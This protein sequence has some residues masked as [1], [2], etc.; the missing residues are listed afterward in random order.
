MGDINQ[1][2]YINFIP[3]SAEH[4]QFKNNLK[5]L[6]G[7]KLV[8]HMSEFEWMVKVIPDHISHDLQQEMSTASQIFMLPVLLKNEACYSDCLHILDSYVEDIN[9]IYTKACRGNF[10]NV[11]H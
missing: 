4:I 11:K 3:T 7:R 6:L 2:S 10:F 8:Y 5:F 1:L 9:R